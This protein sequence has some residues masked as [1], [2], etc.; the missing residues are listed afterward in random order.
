MLNLRK[1]TSENFNSST[2]TRPRS[3]DNGNDEPDDSPPPKKRKTGN[4]VTAKDLPRPVTTTEDVFKELSS[5][6]GETNHRCL[7]LALAH[8]SP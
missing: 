7:M 2:P 6:N 3:P 4:G 8:I 1:Q 5:G